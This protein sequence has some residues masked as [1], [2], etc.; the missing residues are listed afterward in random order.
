MG[1]IVL[2]DVS[3]SD[4][5][6]AA[7]VRGK[8]LRRNSRVSTDSGAEAINVVWTQTLRE[9]EV[10]FIPMVREA[11]QDIETLH[12]ITEG[13][14]YGFLMEDPKDCLVTT[15][16]GVAVALTS[17]TFQL[18][19]RSLHAASGRY[20]DRKIT[21]PQ[22]GTVAVFVS[23]APVAFTLD[24]DTGIATIPSAPAASSISWDGRFYLPVHFM[25]DFIDWSIAKPGS[26]DGRYIAG[27][28]VVLREIRE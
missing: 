8:Q 15:D 6:I 4:R 11:W 2:S 20:K 16:I 26:L 12:E 18:Y 13:G 25:D 1:I 3:L 14:A 17:T 5:V 22:A 28:S 27:P 21:R 10:G 19:K 24:E 9:F 7:G 23:G